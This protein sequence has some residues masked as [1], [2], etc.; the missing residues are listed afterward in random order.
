M[1]T[2]VYAGTR[3]MKRKRRTPARTMSKATSRIV[4][5]KWIVAVALVIAF[6]V[7]TE[8]V[9]NPDFA[10]FFAMCVGLIALFH[11]GFSIRRYG[12]NLISGWKFWAL[13]ALSVALMFGAEQLKTY[14]LWTVF[15][16]KNV[17]IIQLCW[18]ESYLVVAFYAVTMIVIVPLAENLFLRKGMLACNNRL[19]LAV[20][21]I[22]SLLVRGLFYAH[23][24]V[25]IISYAVAALPL[26]VIFLKTRNIYITLTAQIIISAY[27]VIPDI[28]YDVARLM[29]R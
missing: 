16:G 22:V 26:T 9:N 23:G 7:I 10:I 19:I 4:Y 25:G 24:I 27:L 5:A 8:V 11:K 12:R 29:L 13:T 3:P 15:S 2:T 20:M 1:D 28:V 21:V 14:L 18:K 17:D 6:S